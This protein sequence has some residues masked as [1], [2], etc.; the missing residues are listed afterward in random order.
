MGLYKTT[1]GFDPGRH[2]HQ[3]DQTGPKCYT[4]LKMGHDRI[5]RPAVCTSWELVENAPGCG[6][7]FAKMLVTCHGAEQ[8]VTF[9]MGTVDWTLDELA[10]KF[11]Q[12]RWF[13]PHQVSSV[14]EYR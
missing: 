14:R 1:V 5:F 4:C 9:D 2:K 3:W 6:K 12:H 8:E 7:P 13:D 11:Q 10:K